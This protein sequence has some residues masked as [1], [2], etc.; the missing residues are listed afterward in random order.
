MSKKIP[1]MWFWLG[2]VGVTLADIWIGILAIPQ[3]DELFLQFLIGLAMVSAWLT[4]VQI[5]VLDRFRAE[6]AEKGGA[7]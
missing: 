7:A 6:L 5:I 2:L 4:S 3:I 1:V